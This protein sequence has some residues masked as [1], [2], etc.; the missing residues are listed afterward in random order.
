MALLKSPERSWLIAGFSGL[1]L[2]LGLSSFVS[3]QNATQLIKN[4]NKSQQTY[5]AIRTLDRVFTDITSAE[6]ARRGYIYLNNKDE[7]DRYNQVVK[8]IEPN[9]QKLRQQFSDN[10]DA[11]QRID[12]LSRLTLQRIELL[13][14][15]I[16]LVD[17]TAQ[18]ND[19][20][21]TQSLITNRSI[22]LRSEIQ[23][24][25]DALQ[26]QE[27]LELKQSVQASEINIQNRK[28][29]EIWLMLF[30][31]MCVSI[32]FSALYRQLMK[33][34][35][36]EALQ[37]RL[38]QEQELSDLKLRFFSMVSHEFRT[39]LTII[40]GAVQ[41][42]IERNSTWS[43]ERRS[44]NLQRIQSAATTMKQY[45]SDVLMLTRAEAGKLECKP[46]SLD[47]EA[48]CLNLI[49]DINCSNRSSHIIRFISNCVITRVYLDERLIY[50]I[51]GNLLLN[52][53]KYSSAGS[54]IDLILSCTEQTVTFQVRDQGFGISQ[55]DQNKIFDLFYRGE[56]SVQAP[57]TGL[58]LAVV[59]KC[60][61]LQH[62]EISI[63]SELD[64]GTTFTVKLPCSRST[65][66]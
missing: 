62:G 25:I 27:E 38:Q 54:E 63:D 15:S 64:R 53:I 31:F 3:Y 28:L 56:N 52:S 7:R 22:A 5:E 21:L 2:C 12:Y 49:E 44:K 37:Q 8:R 57:G 66:A 4:S 35:Q 30:G 42:S 51:L 24:E 40:L 46:E 19:L 10:P 39:P 43:E 59:K 23:T 48:F 41:L 34:Q 1:T 18:P 20:S 13:N 61:D 45:L 11:L 33:R 60:I 16:R 58:G 17:N 32:C 65:E 47:L 26:T 29:I 9:L 36:V 55:A 50:S 6:S 14:K